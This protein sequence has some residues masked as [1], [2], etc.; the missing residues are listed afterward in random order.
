M[1]ASK[2]DQLRA[3]REGRTPSS[4]TQKTS[5]P[6]AGAPVVRESSSSKSIPVGTKEPTV[7]PATKRG[8]PR[9]EVRDKT[10]KATKPW[11]KLGMSER[12]W[13]RRQKESKGSK[14]SKGSM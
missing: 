1:T 13:Y 9:L 5:E 14:G 3:L 12:T 6:S 11:E 7:S 4:Q 8:R 2:L 10:H